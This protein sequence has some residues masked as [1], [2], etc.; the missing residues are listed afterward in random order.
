MK[1]SAS[2]RCGFL[3]VLITAISLWKVQFSLPLLWERGSRF[4][5][6][7]RAMVPPDLSYVPVV[8]RPLW[9][10][11]QMSVAGT[12]LGAIAGFLGAVFANSYT[13][14]LPYLRIPFKAVVHLIRTVP[15]LI[16]ALVCTF[17]V[18]IGS[19]A[20]TI[21]LFLSTTVV[22]TR[23]GY[24]DMENAN[25]KVPRCLEV[26]GCSRLRA[27]IRTV[28]PHVLPGYLTNVLYLFESNVRHAS[29]LGYVG[30]GGIGLLLNE[31]IAWRQ[32]HEV[33]AILMLLYGIVLMTE[34]V[35]EWLRKVLEG[36]RTLGKNGKLAVAA[37]VTTLFTASLVT[38][39]WP[40]E[41]GRGNAAASAIFAGICHPD[42]AMLFSLSHNDVPYL[43]VE[44]FCIAFLGTLGGTLIAVWL[45]FFASF[46][47]LPFPVALVSRM[48]L[49]L[50]RT[51]PAFVY[52]LMWIRVT[53]PGPFAGALTLALC[54]IGLLAKRF[55]IAID[56]IQLGPYAA[57][58][59]MGV[60]S[61][62]AFW[63]TV[64]P[65]LSGRYAAAILYRMD[66]NIREAAILG[67]VGAG[68]IGTPLILAMMHYE[69]PQV[70]ALF[71]GM[72]LLVTI[73]DV[74]SELWR[75]KNRKS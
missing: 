47:I 2:L 31:R 33:G 50:I 24:E 55:L 7:A 38:L 45:S 4:F 14:P 74:L 69:W 66:V 22:M 34:G 68:G 41:W 56:E 32:Y 58:R 52:G 59:A 6:I 62:R 72:V 39:E 12:V 70:G 54:S 71:W 17:F 46:R 20:G 19:L 15:A 27:F 30:A 8:L 44:T 21:A 49:L 67:V 23:I 40:T 73:V 1:K 65:Q 9:A 63:R 51:V 35:S 3:F 61:V 29:I 18:G 11:V 43:L 16:L 42:T 64:R 5:D 37:I 10:T 60:P 28:L 25:L 53:G 75:K 26:A 13:N 36:K 57:S 48:G